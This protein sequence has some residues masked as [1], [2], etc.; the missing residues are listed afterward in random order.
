MSLL[1]LVRI[2]VGE[3]GVEPGSVK[4]VD[5]GSLSVITAAGYLNGISNGSL[6]SG[7]Q[8]S[9]SDLIECL[10]SYNESTGSGTFGWFQ[11]SISNGVVTLVGISEGD[12]VLPSIA[13]HIVY[14][15]DTSGNMSTANGVNVIN[16][17]NIQAGLSGTAG[18][19]AS[20]PS[21][22]AKG[23]LRLTAVANTGDTLVTI[24]NAL[25]GQASVYSIP[26]GGQATAEFIISDSA[27]IQHI[28]SGSLEVDD[29]DLIAGSD[30][31]AGVFQSFPATTA[32]GSLKVAAVDSSMDVVVTISNADHAQATVVSIPDGGQATAEFI[33]SDSAGTQH[34]T[35]GGLQV[36]AGA[37]SSGLAA[38]GFAG[39]VVLHAN[40]TASGN[41]A[42]LAVDNASGDFDTVISNAAAVGQDQVIS[43]PDSG[44]AT[45]NFLLDTG[46]ANIIAKQEFLG[47]SQ[48]LT[49]GTGT[50][51]VTRIAQGNYVSRHTPGDETSII[52]VD[53][54]PMIVA[55]ASKGFRLDSFDV[56]YAI[57][58]NALDAH[59]VVLDRIAYAD[60][61]A[62]SVTS[63]PIT[64]TLATAT[65][66]NPYVTNVVVDTPAFDVTADSKYVMELTVNNAAASEYDYYG[67][68]LRFSQ[69]IA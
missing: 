52:A 49:F 44:A 39:N 24:S 9:P 11:P 53:I 29:G 31:N 22:A 16:G 18:L 15:T 41:L 45:A 36:D 61:V 55:A 40:T 65:Q 50:W 14:A 58:A 35:S 63:I 26:D 68:M 42:L 30:A 47:L 66:A 56:I 43:I 38:G 8:L 64:G 28:T 32:S 54:T 5:T 10:Y 4:M 33:I 67:I 51:T 27:G 2:S 17:G 19:L 59:S 20:F 6:I 3:V 60:N 69:T 34:I 21:A 25:H 7:V 48:V 13:N 1:S 62:V 57:A 23:S 37:V 46:A 12:I